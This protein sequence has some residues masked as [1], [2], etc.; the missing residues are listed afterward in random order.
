M[1]DSESTVTST[2]GCGPTT[3]SADTAGT[4]LTCSATSGGGTSSQ[5]VTIKR[6]ATAPT[7]NGSASPGP[8]GAGWNKTDVD[9]S[10]TCGDATSGIASCSPNQTLSV[11]GASQS[12]TGTAIDNAGNSAS[13]TVSGINI[14]KTAPSVAV[15]GVTNGATYTLGSVPAAGCSTTDALSGVATWAS[16]AMSGGPVVGSFTATCGGATDNADNAAASASATYNVIY[17]FAGFFR[18]VDNLPTMNIVKAGSAVPV[19]FSLNG[20]HGLGIFASGYPRSVSTS[21]TNTTQDSIEE[22]VTAGNSSLS[23][24]PVADQYNYVWKTDKSWTGCREL[25]VMFNDG[26]TQKAMFKFTK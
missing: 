8:N 17:N 3:V 20:N 22:T 9:V 23:Y 24:D 18:P 15:T 25:Q 12:A 10:F 26:T 21:C 11:E 6:D 2:T 4:T 1:T 19:K 7:I 16:L 5:S 13:T 14:D